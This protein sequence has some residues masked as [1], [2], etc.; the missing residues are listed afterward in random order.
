MAKRSSGSSA[1]DARAKKSAKVIRDSQIDFSDIPELTDAQ[2][3]RGKRLGRPLIG[4]LPRRLI[5]IRLDP[6]ILDQIKK[7][8]KKRKKGYQTLI[9]EIL[10][11][12][13]SKKDKAG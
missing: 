5:A 10:S 8:A 1:R 9:N 11:E 2:L 12:H 4:L 13:F 3:A 6:Q 7:Q